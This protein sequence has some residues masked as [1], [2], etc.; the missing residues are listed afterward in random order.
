MKIN[1][2]GF[3]VQPGE[4]VKLTE[5]PTIVKP[6]CKSKKAYQ[7]LLKEHVASSSPSSISGLITAF[8]PPRRVRETVRGLDESNAHGIERGMAPPVRRGG[9]AAAVKERGSVL[10][11]ARGC[12]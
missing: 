3:R 6:S 7:K 5:W 11:S 1:S 9:G 2:K 8:A 10:S 4:E 12:A